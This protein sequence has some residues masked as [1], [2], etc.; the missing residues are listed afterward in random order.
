LLLHFPLYGLLIPF[1]RKKTHRTVFYDSV[2][3]ALLVL[4]IIPYWIALFF[5]F[6]YIF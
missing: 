1:V 4:T 6:S 3:L 2:L 5:I